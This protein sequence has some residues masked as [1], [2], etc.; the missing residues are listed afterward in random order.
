M[1][2]MLSGLK[3]RMPLMSSCEWEKANRAVLCC[4]IQGSSSSCACSCAACTLII[5]EC[6]ALSAGPDECRGVR[7]LRSLRAHL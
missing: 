2:F 7:R 6:S 5:S 4:D 3:L 1:T